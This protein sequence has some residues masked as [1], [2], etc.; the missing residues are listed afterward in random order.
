MH[1]YCLAVC[2][3]DLLVRKEICRYCDK[4]LEGEGIAHQIIEYPSAEEL[5]KAIEIDG[6]AFHLLILDIRL[7]GK[8][9]MELAQEL[10][11]RNDETSILF[12]TGYDEYMEQGYEVQAEDGWRIGSVTYGQE[13][14]AED[15]SLEDSVFTAPALNQDGNVLTV[16]IE[17]DP[18]WKKTE[19][20]TNNAGGDSKTGSR[21]AGVKTGDEIPIEIFIMGS[22]LS[23]AVAAGCVIMLRSRKN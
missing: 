3:D 8:S 17:E 13:G 20:G 4:I 1:P 2:E 23:L 18:D 7:E 9:G 5:E 22:L 12:I 14:Q 6:Q 10:R 19:I 16:T 21:S 11:N 15:V